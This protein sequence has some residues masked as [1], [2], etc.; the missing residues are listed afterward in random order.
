MEY[1]ILEFGAKG[2]GQTNDTAAIQAA[3]DF[4]EE[5]LN[6]KMDRTTHV[7]THKRWNNQCIKEQCPFFGGDCQ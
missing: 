2:D 6:I 7:C 1:N 5:H 4:A 3:I